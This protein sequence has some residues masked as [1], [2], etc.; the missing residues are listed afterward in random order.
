[1]FGCMAK[2]AQLDDIVDALE[3][4]FDE[5]P[6][7]L[8]LDTG[9]VETVSLEL[10]REAE[11]GD[12]EEEPDLPEWQKAEWELAKRIVS[13]DRFER[14]PTKFDV[15]EWGIMRD[16]SENAK[17]EGIR[18]ELLDAIHGAGAFRNFRAVVRRHRMEEAWDAFEGEALRQ[19]A[20]DWCEEHQIEWE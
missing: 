10:L 16:F 4:V 19:I 6:S 7:Y 2:P 14:L 11:D 15:D 12:D 18:R 13:S 17:P 8:D 1:M 9:E 5:S 20:I 3:M